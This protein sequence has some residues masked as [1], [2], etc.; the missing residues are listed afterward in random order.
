VGVKKER[1]VIGAF[2]SAEIVLEELFFVFEA[3]GDGNGKVILDDRG[4][5]FFCL[6]LAGA[7][8]D[9]E[10]ERDVL[11]GALGGFAGEKLGLVED[12]A[13]A[14]EN[15][16]LVLVVRD[17][18]FCQLERKGIKFD[19]RKVFQKNGELFLYDVVIMTDTASFQLKQLAHLI[20]PV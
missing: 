8:F 9:A 19:N 1:R 17:R 16:V 14:A 12:E 15:V 7:R 5:Q 2:Y 6:G 11:N 20:L 13:C 4:C 18:R 10:D 3:I